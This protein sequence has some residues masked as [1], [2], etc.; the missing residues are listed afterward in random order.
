[1]IQIL[2]LYLDL[3][4]AVRQIV[5]NNVDDIN[6][7]GRHDIL[8]ILDKK[9]KSCFLYFRLFPKL[10]KQICHSKSWI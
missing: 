7:T 2:I 10:C 8:K 9:R 3:V 6:L 5:R 4:T 1:M